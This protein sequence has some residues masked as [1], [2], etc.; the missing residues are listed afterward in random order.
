MKGYE[1]L[2]SRHSKT[3]LHLNTEHHLL[4]SFN[5]PNIRFKIIKITYTLKAVKLYIY[6]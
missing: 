6:N 1:C 3:H 4:L 2:D 5:I